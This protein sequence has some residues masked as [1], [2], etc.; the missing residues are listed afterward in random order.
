MQLSFD[1][2]ETV[3]LFHLTFD[4]N[5]D[6]CNGKF[7]SGLLVE[8]LLFF[9][10]GKQLLARPVKVWDVPRYQRA[11][12]IPVTQEMFANNTKIGICFATSDAEI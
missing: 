7:V 11:T 8:L 5:N 9:Q 1:Y 2:T 4:L 6:P 3:K 10:N 12:T